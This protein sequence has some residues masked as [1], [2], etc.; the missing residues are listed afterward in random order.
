MQLREVDNEVLR[1]VEDYVNSSDNSDFFISKRRKV[2]NGLDFYM[3]LN[4]LTAGLGRELFRR[5]GGELKVSKRL[6][7]Q[8]H[9][10]SRLLYRVT[11]LYRMG[12]FKPGDF[13]L[14]EGKAFKVTGIS[15]GS[16]Y[17]L[18]LDSLRQVELEVKLVNRNAEKL[19]PV[20][21]IISK[22]RPQLEVI[23]PSTFQSTSVLPRTS[24]SKHSPEEKVYVVVAGEKVWLTT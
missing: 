3:S 6:F 11:V 12:R 23:H 14:Y 16:V 22:V 15:K 24:G 20:K 4:Q 5:F 10:T 9:M 13:I 21:A 1:F 18:N 2:Q 19:K 17:G 8:H 7:S